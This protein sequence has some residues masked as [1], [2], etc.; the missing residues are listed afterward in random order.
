MIWSET[1]TKVTD[2]KQC[3]HKIKKVALKKR[4]HRNEVMHTQLC[5]N[6]TLSFTKKTTSQIW[7]QETPKLIITQISH[8]QNIVG[9][10]Y[11]FITKA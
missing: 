1:L 6:V 5:T 2:T 3:K 7:F 4:S 8:F 10:V 9:N 11:Q